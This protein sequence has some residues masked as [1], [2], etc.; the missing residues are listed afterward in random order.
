MHGVRAIYYFF[1][2]VL[3]TQANAVAAA[4]TMPGDASFSNKQ[5][6]CVV[7]LEPDTKNDYEEP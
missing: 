5:D 6:Q 7:V 3:S 1:Q 2:G 4:V